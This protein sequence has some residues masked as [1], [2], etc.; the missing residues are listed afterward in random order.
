ML[1]EEVYL[2][3]GTWLL[4]PVH[5]GRPRQLLIP[6]ATRTEPGPR[7]QAIRKRDQEVGRLGDEAPLRVFP[8]IKE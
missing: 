6:L 4:L 5:P 7:P 3:S 1:F 2:S 8:R